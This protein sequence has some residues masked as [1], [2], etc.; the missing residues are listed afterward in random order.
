MLAV[1]WLGLLVS[2]ILFALLLR[3][4]HRLL[5]VLVAVGL[6]EAGR[7]L[8]VLLAGDTLTAM[9]VGGAFTRVSTQALPALLVQ[10]GG[11][12]AGAGVGLLFGRQTSRDTLL[13]AAV[14]GGVILF[15][16]A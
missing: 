11:L 4:R 15:F 13:Y 9:T 6:G 8:L 5:R 14:A 10:V 7:A 12:V 3:G 16:R 2:G 1:D